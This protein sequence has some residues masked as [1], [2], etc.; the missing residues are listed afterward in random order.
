MNPFYTLLSH[1]SY[2]LISSLYIFQRLAGRF[3][4]AGA[5]FMP[6]H[7]INLCSLLILSS[8]ACL[9]LPAILFH[10]VLRPKFHTQVSFL[11]FVFYLPRLIFLIKYSELVQITKL[12]IIRFSLPSR[13]FVPLGKVKFPHTGPVV[14]QRVGRGIALLF[15]DRGT[16][17]R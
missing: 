7:S 11:L 13:N 3:F 15:H 1:L 12:F 6:L 9:V 4:T 10:Q 8:L 16:R 14:A 5:V 2:V 17:R